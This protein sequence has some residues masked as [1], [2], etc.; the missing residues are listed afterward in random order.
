[1][2]HPKPQ[3]KRNLQIPIALKESYENTCILEMK[4]DDWEK[5]FFFLAGA[6]H[7]QQLSNSKTKSPLI[8]M[9]YVS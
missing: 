7:R 5:R 2:K 1:M 8:F 4:M 3:G 6:K 9:D